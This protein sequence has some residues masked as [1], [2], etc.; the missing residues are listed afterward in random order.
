MD[1]YFR[2][3]LTGKIAATMHCHGMDM[4]VCRAQ[5]A[6]AAVAQLPPQMQSHVKTV[7]RHKTLQE[8]YMYPDEMTRD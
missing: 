3:E 2:I 5:T 7:R 8:C 6:E 4:A 1:Y